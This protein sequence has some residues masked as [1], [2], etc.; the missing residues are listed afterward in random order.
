MEAAAG[1]RIVQ[2]GDGVEESRRLL[3]GTLIDIQDILMNTESH[4][5]P[6]QLI[7]YKIDKQINTEP[8]YTKG[9]FDV[10]GYIITT[11]R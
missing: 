3:Q 11:N 2:E 10:I 8:P 9:R 4:K 7:T 1:G 6:Q 5:I